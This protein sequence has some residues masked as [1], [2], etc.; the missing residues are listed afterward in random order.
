LTIDKASD[1]KNLSENPEKQ[2]KK[3]ARGQYTRIFKPHLGFATII[4]ELWLETLLCMAC[5]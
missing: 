5:Q 4:Y 2:V 3:V 1:E